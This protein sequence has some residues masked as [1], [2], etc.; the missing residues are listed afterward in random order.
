MIFRLANELDKE[1]IYN[2]YKSMLGIQFCVWSEEYPSMININIDIENNNLFI[3]E[4]NDIIVGAISIEVES[5]VEDF[6][7]WKC[8]DGTQ[9]EIAR[10]VINQEYQGQGLAKK[11]MENIYPV[12]KSRGCNAIHLAVSKF[13]I[14]ANKTY[15]KLGFIK[16][17]EA[18]IFNGEYY[19]MEKILK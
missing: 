10:I 5:E 19:L 16:Q 15:E 13:N 7:F 1:P 6:E 18:N 4:E 12:L 9:V 8:N 14:P 2:L 17:G 3:L 11:L